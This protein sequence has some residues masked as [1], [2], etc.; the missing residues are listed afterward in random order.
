MI[1]DFELLDI[2][3][4]VKFLEKAISSEPA[5]EG[6]SFNAEWISDGLLN[7]FAS[8]QAKMLV[9]DDKGI[10]GV[11][12]GG[13]NYF[14]LTGEPTAECAFCWANGQTKPLREA[15]EAW[16]KEQGVTRVVYQAFKRQTAAY[17]KQGYKQFSTIFVRNG[18]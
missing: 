1:R 18:Q 14:L 10:K 3:S 9:V 6:V 17:K 4:T 5:F 13:L 16:A 2:P 11:L 8:K 7:L 15:F 12:V